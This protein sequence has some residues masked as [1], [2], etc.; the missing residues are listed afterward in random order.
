MHLGIKKSNP[1]FY[2]DILIHHK[3]IQVL[4]ISDFS[5]SAHL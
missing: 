5:D 4:I 1:K 3:D 2:L